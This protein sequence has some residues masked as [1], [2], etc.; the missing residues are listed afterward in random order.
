MASTVEEIK[1]RLSITEVVSGYLKLERAGSNFRARCPFHNEKTPSFFVSPVRGTY[2]CFGCN[3]GG[4]MISFVQELEGLD[5]TGALKVL[6]DRAGVVIK[7]EKP[8]ERSEKEKVRK[9][10]EDAVVYFT[11]QIEKQ[12]EVLSYLKSRGLKDQTREEFKIGFAPDGWSNLIDYLKARGHT[13]DLIEKAGLAVKGDKRPYDRFRSRIMFPLYDTSG[14]VVGFSGRIFGD[15]KDEESAKYVNSPQTVL[16]DKSRV[17]YGFD[18]AKTEIRKADTCVL[19]EGQ[20]DVIMSQ[21]VGVRNAVAV[22]GTALTGEHLKIINRLAS[23]LVV[24]FDSDEAGLAALH[25]ATEMAIPMGFN[26][27]AV[28]LEGAKD[29][30]DLARDNP[31]LLKKAVGGAINVV[32]F[33]IGLLQEKYSD[34][35][36]LRLAAQKQIL[37]LVALIPNKIDQAHYVE[38]L[39]GTLDLPSQPIYDELSKVNKPAQREELPVAPRATSSRKQMIEE[40]IA[41]IL[42]WQ[43]QIPEEN[44]RDLILIAEA[45]YDG[46]EHIEDELKRLENELKRERLKEELQDVMSKIKKAESGGKK[47]DEINKYLVKCQEILIALNNLND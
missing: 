9:V 46:S 31:D 15:G 18:R 47:E 38:K 7:F 16:Y 1:S 17:L 39:A 6:A 35:R 40:M 37:P 19:V 36:E 3:K 30:A 29:P 44:G 34:K 8:G 21:Q 4:D 2:H 32:D 41:G 11:S 27:R 10:L 26:V 23:N 24:A 20:M 33:L 43:A 28:P 25:R 45:Y 13:A 5:F 22:S 42:L 14:Q 12:T